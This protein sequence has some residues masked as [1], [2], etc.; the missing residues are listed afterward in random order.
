[1]C[2]SLLEFASVIKP[3]HATCLFLYSL[4][5]SDVLGSRGSYQSEAATGGVL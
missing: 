3:F 5:V 4:G 1:M 2:N